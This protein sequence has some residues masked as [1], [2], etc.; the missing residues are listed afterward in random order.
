MS[1]GLGLFGMPVTDAASVVNGYGS[2]F[3]AKHNL[4]SHF[5]GG[6]RLDLAPPGVVKDFVANS[7][8]HSV[9]TSVRLLVIQPCLPL[10]VVDAG[11]RRRDCTI[12]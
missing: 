11:G 10:F 12:P 3:A 1:S 8:G 2:S 5:I 4:P 6:N 9:V 7:D